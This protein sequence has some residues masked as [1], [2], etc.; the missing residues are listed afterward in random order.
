VPL[1]VAARMPLPHTNDPNAQTDWEYF[2]EV[3]RPLLEH[4]HVEFVGE[5]AGADKDKLLGGAVALLLRS[6]ADGDSRGQSVNGT[7]SARSTRRSCRRHSR[8]DSSSCSCVRP[9]CASARSS[10]YAGPM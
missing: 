7:S 10:S 5:L 9:G 3:V 8:T 2:E 4:D 6:A 1:K